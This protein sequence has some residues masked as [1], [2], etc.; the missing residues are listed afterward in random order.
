MRKVIFLDRDGVINKE[1]GDYTFKIIDFE[2]NEGVFDFLKTAQEKGFE[3]ILITNQGGISKGIYNKNDVY[4]VHAH[5]LT[6]FNNVGLTILEVY[7]C[8]HHS[9]VEKCI[10]RKPDSLMLEKAIARFNID[11]AMSFMIGDSQRDIDA[12][13]KVGIRSFIIEP[14]S[15][16]NQLKNYLF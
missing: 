10:C 6:Q 16:L 7:F 12:A 8:P 14:N 3:F 2:I 13:T 9:D 5:M 15:N 4:L 1:R 11:K